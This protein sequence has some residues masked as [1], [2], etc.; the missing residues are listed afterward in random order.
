MEEIRCRR[1]GETRSALDR[2]PF[3]GERGDRVRA[4]ICPP[5]WGDWLKHQTLLINHY[6]L[7]P[8]EAKARE[9]LYKQID[10]ALLGDA[11][12]EQ[13]DTSKKGTIEWK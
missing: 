9:F 4:S 8:R 11:S 1:C 5:C 3:R 13:V 10:E 7:D 12:A 2:P 6:G